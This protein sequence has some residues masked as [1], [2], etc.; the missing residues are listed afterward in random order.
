MF[1]RGDG[2]GREL[3]RERRGKGAAFGARVIFGLGFG[4]IGKRR[5]PQIP[6]D[7]VSA[8]MLFDR[9]G[10]IVGLFGDVVPISEPADV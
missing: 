8:V 3:N 9:G 6:V 1:L 4:L 5:R 2:D 7:V 10:R